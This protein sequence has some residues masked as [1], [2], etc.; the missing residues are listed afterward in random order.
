MLPSS[1][2]RTKLQVLGMSLL[3]ATSTLAAPSALG[4][5]ND[6]SCKPNNDWFG[7]PVPNPPEG[8]N[9]PFAFK[10]GKDLSTN[11]DFHQW[12]WN[13]FLYLTQPEKR[14]PG[15]LLMFGPGFWQVDNALKP[16]FAPWNDILNPTGLRPANVLILEDINQAGSNGV[17]Y[18]KFGGTPV[19]YSI[20][21][22]DTYMKSA[23]SHPKA[24]SKAEFAVG[25]VELKVAWMD[26]K[27]LKQ[28][29]PK[30]DLAEH[31]YIRK[32]VYQK[33][34]K[35]S[36][37]GEVA[38]VGMHV[39]GVVEN[40]PEFIWATFKHKLSAPD[41]Y[42]SE[43]KFKKNTAYLQQDKVVSNSH[44]L[45]FYRGGTEVQNAHLTYPASETTTN[46][47]RLYQYGVPNGNPYIAGNNPELVGS[48][49][50]QAQDETNFN[51]I[52]ELNSLVNVKLE[53]NNPVWSNYFYAGSIWL[54]TLDYDFANG[55]SGNI[56]GKKANAALRGSLAV[57]NITMETYTQTSID[58]DVTGSEPQIKSSNCFSCHGI[59]AGES[60]MQVSHIYN[61]YLT[62]MQKSQ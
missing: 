18:S 53:Q 41:Y 30:L 32:A 11:C 54:S 15:G 40:H 4:Y 37:T 39:V 48:Q 21:V 20:H 36:G 60:T 33:D 56:V 19:H 1:I 10:D 16:Y 45:L 55:I 59:S 51:N 12:S 5:S 14:A 7:S 58:S 44:D 8:A 13:K 31:F 38:L 52:T 2:T 57:A 50:Q 28:V 3:L 61:S 62:L 26:I 27:A 42:S 23:M 34:N 24:D 25:S 17:I 43:G 6:T 46:T 9:S 29:Y 22:N 35:Y 49:T 47:F